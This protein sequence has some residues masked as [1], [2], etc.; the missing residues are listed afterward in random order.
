MIEIKNIEEYGQ[1]TLFSKPDYNGES[2]YY[3]NEQ[4][5][6]SYTGILIETVAHDITIWWSE[7]IDGFQNGIEK[8]FNGDGQLE[9]ISECKYNM[10]VGISKEYDEQGNLILVAIKWNNGYIKSMDVDINKKIINK[11]EY[12]RWLNNYPIPDDFKK[13]LNL[14]D[15]EL[16]D[17][18]FAYN[19]WKE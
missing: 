11:E 3:L 5:E 10:H 14:T 4:L 15:Q 1:G 13:L 19:L 8:I 12:E 16:I 2:I 9:Q 18:E 7:Y 6:Q 17:Y